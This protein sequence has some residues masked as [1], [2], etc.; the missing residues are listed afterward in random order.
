MG[1][2]IVEAKDIDEALGTIRAIEM[3]RYALDETK[4]NLKFSRPIY[5]C[6]DILTGIHVDLVSRLP[7]EVIERER[8]KASAPPSPILRA[9]TMPKGQ[10]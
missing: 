3:M 2:P 5:H 1:D 6:M 10:A 8:A 4:F 9:N 7:Q